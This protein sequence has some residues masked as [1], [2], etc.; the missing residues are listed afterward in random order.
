VFEKKKSIFWELPYWP[1][2]DVRYCLD[3]MHIIKNIY[4]SL[5]GTLLNIQGKMK[6]GV[7]T[8]KD[9]VAMEIRSELAPQKYEK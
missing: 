7:N 4:E 5:V 9:M 2:L 1:Y 8:R 3:G 6:D